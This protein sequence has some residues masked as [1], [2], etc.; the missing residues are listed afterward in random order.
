MVCLS[1][2]DAILVCVPIGVVLLFRGRL[3]RRERAALAIRLALPPALLLIAFTTWNLA[4]FGTASPVSGQ[5]KSVGA[6]FLNTKPLNRF[7]IG[8]EFAGRPLWIGVVSVFVVTIACIVTLKQDVPTRTLLM[9][10]ALAAMVGEA[11]LLLYL[12]VST[13]YPTWAWYHYPVAFFGFCG[14]V[15]LTGPLVHRFGRPARVVALTLSVVVVTAQ[16]VSIHDN[17][18]IY[19]P[20]VAAAHFVRDNTKPTDVFAMGNRAG[21]FGYLGDRPL[22]QLEGLVA[23]GDYIDDLRRGTILTRAAAVGVDYYVSDGPPGERAIVDGELCREFVEPLNS[24]GPRV[25]DEDRVFSAGHLTIWRFRPEL[26]GT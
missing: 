18:D 12:V 4:V 25:E 3:T 10:I 8:A 19:A 2:L 13:S 15:L 9:R 11:L 24:R 14:V 17:S 1:R 6:P 7:L 21:I 26:N 23:D 22:L 20:S 16:A 5:A